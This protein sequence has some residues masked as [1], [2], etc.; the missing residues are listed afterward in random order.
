ML[1]IRVMSAS[2]SGIR[3]CSI[4]VLYVVLRILFAISSLY[5]SAGAQLSSEGALSTSPT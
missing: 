4:A 1:P 3:F 2:L 5:V